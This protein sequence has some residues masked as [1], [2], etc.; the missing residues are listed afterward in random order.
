[1]ANKMVHRVLIDN[2]SS[3]D[4]IFASAFDKM[5]IGRERMEPVSTHLQGFSGEKVLPLG[6]I[7]LVLTLGD[8]PCQ[9]TTTARFLV[10]DAPSAYNMLLDKPSLNAIKSIP[11]AYHMMIKFP[12]VSGVGMVR[13]DQRVAR[14]CYSASMKQK[15]VDNIY[16]DELDKRDEVLTRPEPSEEMEHVP[17]DDDP[18]HLAYIGSK[19]TKD[20][21]SPLTHFL[22]QNKDVFAWKQADMGGIDP[23]II[24]HRLN[25]SPSFKPVK[26][27]RRSFAPKRQ[28]AINEEVGKL[29]H[30]GAIREVEY[31]EWLANVVLAKK[32]N[33]KWRLCIDF[34]DV[35]RA[36]P[37]DNFPLPRIDLS[38]DATAGHELLSFMDA[39]SGYNQISMDLDDQEKTSFVTGQ[40][41]YCYRVMPFRLKNAGATYQRLVNR[42]FQK[43]IG[44]TMEVYIDDML[45]KSTTAELHIAHLSEAFQILRKY[46]MK[47][48]PAKCA[49]EVSAGKFLGFIVNNRGIEANPNKIK[50]VL[51]MPLPSGIKKVQRLTGRIDALSRF[52]SR[53]SDK[54]QPL[55]RVLKKAF[56]WDTK[57]EETFSALKTYLSPPP[58]PPPPP[59]IMVS[60]IE[61]ELLT[62]YLAVSDFST[63]TVLVRDKDRVQHP[64]YY[65]NRALRGAEERYP[66]MEK[67]ILALVTAARKLRPYFQAHTIEVPTEYP[68]KQ[69]LHK[70]ETSGRLM[71]WVIELSEFD[72]R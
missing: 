56:Q 62:L 26:Q 53:A 49:F 16:L 72:I 71:K 20:L 52:V 13:G 57:C 70:P 35:N 50:V 63:S 64:V 43:H 59:P 11:S 33:G 19:L 65:C 9:A 36:C 55:F 68:M 21:K 3:A 12:T 46:N 18:E 17:L 23:T 1:M 48:N 27:K 60:P 24:T 28:K 29:L 61:G 10:V 31:P 44:T 15:T 39:F 32:A 8:P 69:V 51:D 14:E 66:R 40:G 4:I 47:L 34:T 2:G 41:T 5:G 37:K 45:V 54:C 7:Q 38:V 6:S 67:L 22:R 25:I 30:A 58:P 42:M